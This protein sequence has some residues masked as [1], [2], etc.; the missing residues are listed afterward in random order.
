MLRPIPLDYNLSGSDDQ[1]HS[2]CLADKSLRSNPFT[3]LRSLLVQVEPLVEKNLLDFQAFQRGARISGEDVLATS[4]CCR[5]HC[6]C[7]QRED[8]DV[9]IHA[10]AGRDRELAQALSNDWDSG[11]FPNSAAKQKPVTE[12]SP[13]GLLV[14]Q[15]QRAAAYPASL[16]SPPEGSYQLLEAVQR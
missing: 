12:L 13:E 1:Q 8:T 3:R 6:W 15:G 16:A 5:A 10:I 11:R 9:L 2:A 4:G 7:A 14:F